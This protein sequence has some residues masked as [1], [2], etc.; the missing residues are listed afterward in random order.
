[1]G[2]V[3]TTISKTISNLSKGVVTD[4]ALYILIG[5]CF[6][7]FIHTFNGLM[8]DMNSVIVSCVIVLIAANNYPGDVQS[9]GSVGL[10]KFFKQ[11]QLLIRDNFHQNFMLK[12][13][14]G[15]P[16]APGGESDS[17]ND[18]E[19]RIY[20]AGL[21]SSAYGRP[22]DPSDLVRDNEGLYVYPPYE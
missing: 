18:R 19:E 17:E 22:V 7:L 3:L 21:I 10:K 11:N 9:V 8:F 14:S 12:S 1:M 13:F 20:S 6:Y 5:I 16:L 2:V 4:Y 15:T